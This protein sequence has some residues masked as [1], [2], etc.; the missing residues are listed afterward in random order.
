MLVLRIPGAKRAEIYLARFLGWM[1]MAAC[2]CCMVTYFSAQE[3][4]H[5]F[6]L[7][8]NSLMLQNTHRTKDNGYKLCSLWKWYRKCLNI[9]DFYMSNR[10]IYILTLIISTVW[11]RMF[12]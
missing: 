10:N 12:C 4:L 3:M 11:K 5:Q 9:K 6:S 2:G 8:Y 7:N 1:G